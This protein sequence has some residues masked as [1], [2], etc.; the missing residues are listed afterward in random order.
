MNDQKK[1]VAPVVRIVE[2]A[3]SIVDE[4]M[5]H[6]PNYAQRKKQKLYKLRRELMNE[7]IR[8][9][10]DDNLVIKLELELHQFLETFYSE[11][12]QE[13]NDSDV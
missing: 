1:E 12:R 6:I 8:K 10:R 11:L 13:N 7:Y 4:A 5:G 2:L 9:D 3:L